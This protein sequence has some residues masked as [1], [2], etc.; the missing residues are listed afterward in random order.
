MKN[1]SYLR[2]AIVGA[3]VSSAIFIGIGKSCAQILPGSPTTLWTALLY[4]VSNPTIPDPSND[5]Q[6]GSLESDIVGNTTHASLFTA[7]YDGGTPSL[8]DGQIAFRLRLAEEKNPP[9]FSGSAFVGL[10]ANGDGK[11]DLFL[12]VNNS[13]SADQI[14]IWKAG[15]GANISPNTTT[16]ANTPSFTYTETS[17]N[18]SWIQVTSISDPSATSYD[19]DGGGGTDRFLSFVLPFADVVAAVN[20][21]LTNGFN[22]NSVVA[23]VAATATQANSLNQDLNGVDG[24][25]NSSSTWASLGALTLPYSASGIQVPEPAT[26]TFLI[27]GATY[28]GLCRR[29][30]RLPTNYRISTH[31]PNLVGLAPPSSETKRIPDHDHV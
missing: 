26:G 2:S 9:G 11:L 28:M 16:L 23:Y 14:G 30:K 1:Q 12:G 4:G 8:T 22:Q 24:G 13:G 27:L 17:T 25:V 7:F 3:C 6:T 31:G 18:Y 29:R 15:S 10:D 19:L 21:V 20:S 5:Q